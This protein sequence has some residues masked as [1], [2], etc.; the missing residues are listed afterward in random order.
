M[1]KT[2]ILS[3]LVG[4]PII[5]FLFT[6]NF[7]IGKW[8]FFLAVTL[9]SS[10][11]L[12]KAFISHNS[13]YSIKIANLP[14]KAFTYF[15]IFLIG[16]I[17]SLLT[18]AKTS[19]DSIHLAL[20]LFSIPLLFLGFTM[21]SADSH[22]EGIHGIFL[23]ILNIFYCLIPGFSM[24]WILDLSIGG[25]LLF[26]LLIIIWGTDTGAYFTGRAIG[27]NKLAPTLSPKKTI[28]G[29][30]G[31]II[32]SLLLVG[33]FSQYNDRIQNFGYGILIFITITGSVLGQIGDLVESRIKRF[34]DIKDSGSI[35]PGHGG[36]LD[37]IDGLLLSSPFYLL[38]L[39]AIIEV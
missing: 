13:S 4:L 14:K 7:W 1:L 28:E 9:I 22:E 24:W 2:R 34:C 26:L 21:I 10:Y 19:S 29:A 8:L 33:L 15:I 39:S 37:R 32:L 38:I 23:F 25:D 6:S 35:I 18:Y 16:I 27:K 3:A 31:G 30:L 11:E 20:V 36:I 12:S 17:F 5:Y